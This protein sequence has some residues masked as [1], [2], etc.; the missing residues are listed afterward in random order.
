MS[1][2]SRCRV[3]ATRAVLSACALLSF[4][5]IVGC[6]SS[7]PSSEST[8]PTTPSFTASVSSVGN[9][10]PG[11]IGAV[12]QIVVSN[13]AGAA[14]SSGTVTVTETSATN[15]TVTGTPTG[16]GWTCTVTGQTFSC[17]SSAAEGGG[18]SFPPINVTGNVTGPAGGTVS[19]SISISGG[20]ITGTVNSTPTGISIVAPPTISKAFGASGIGVGGSTSLTFTVANPAANTVV[21]TGLA[22]SDSFPAGLAVAATPGVTDTCSGTVTAAAGSGTISLANGTSAAPGGTCTISVNVTATAAGSFSN[23]VNGAGTVKSSNGGTGVASNTAILNAAGPPT[24]SKAFGAA[25][26]PLTNGNTTLTFTVANPAAN[27]AALTGVAFSDS[28]PAGL[29]MAATPG[30]TDTCGG[31]VTAAAG[32]GTVSLANG[33]SA[34]PG[35]TCTISVNVTGTSAGAKPNTTGAISSTQSGAGAVSNTATLTVVAPPTISKAFGASSVSLNG[36]TSLSF[37]VT[38][39]NA[40]NALSGV[41]F[42]DSLPTGIAVSTPNG[43]TGSCGTGTISAVAGTSSVNL[44]SGTLASGG[45]CNFSVNVTGTTAGALS[46]TTGNVTSAEGGTGSAS[47]TASLAVVAPPTISKAFGASGVAVNATTTLTFTITNPAANTVGLTGVAFSDTLPTGLLIATPNGLANTCNGTPTATAGAGTVSLTGGTVGVSTNCTLTVNVTPTTAGT[48]PNTTGAVSS[49]NGGT[50]AVSNTAMLNGAAPPTISKAFS[51]P[52]IPLSSGNATL[53]FTITNPATNPVALTG[54]AFSDALPTGLVIATP[55][56]LANTCGGTPTATAASGSITLAGGTLPINN[57]CTL[58]VN[59]T[60]TTAGAKL[61][62]TGAVSSTQSGTGAVSNTATLT[63]LAPPTVSKAFGASSVSL[64]GSTSLSFTVT[65]PNATNTLSGVGFSDSLPT[66]LAV[67]TPNGLTGSCGTGTLSAVAGSSSVS[68]SSG[69]LA[70]AGSCNFSVNVTGTTAGSVSNTTGNVTS[71]EGGAGTTS[72]TA[73]LTV[74]APPTISLAFGASGV[75]VNGTTTLTFTITNPS[76]NTAA[77]TGVAF[78]DA[79][80]A[81]LL[82]ATPSGLANTCAGT[83]TAAAGSGSISLT[84][85]TVGVNTTCTLTVNVTPNQAGSFPDTTGAVSSTNGGTGTASNTATLNAA[86]P[87]TISIILGTSEIPLNGS[88]TLT[89]LIANPS[90]NTVTLTGVQ[91]TDNLPA[92]LVLGS[93]PLVSNACGGTT[94]GVTGGPSSVGLSGVTLA[95]NATCAFVV[96]VT[97]TAAGTLNIQTLPIS[98]TQSGAGLASN[99]LVLVVVAPPTISKAFGA[100]GIAVGGATTLTFTI[101]NPAA[102]TVGLTGVA[103]GDTLPTGLV[104]AATPNLT[105][106]CAGTPTASAGSISLVNG[107]IAATG[108]NATCTL[109]VNVTPTVAGVF[110]N[111]TG[112][113]NSTNGGTG[114]VSNTAT[115]SAALPPTI[116]KA[117]GAP[118]IPLNT[119]TSLTFTI[120]N[121]AGNV[122][123]LTGLAFTDNLPTGLVVASTPNISNTC[124]GTPTATAGSGAV[125]L[126]G[127]TIATPGNTCTLSVNVTGNAAGVLSNTTAAVSSTQSGSGAASNTANLT[128][129]APP[130]ISKAFGGPVPV[131]GPTTLTFTITNPAANTVAQ[132]GV[133]FSDTFPTGLVVATPNGLTNTCSGTP[134]ATAGSGSVSLTGGTVAVNTTCTLTVNVTANQPGSLPNATGAIT[135]SNGGTGTA[136]NTANLTVE[137]PP[138]ISVAFGASGVTVGGTTTLTVTITNPA[139]N[140]VAQTG[141][142]FSDTLPTGL[143]IATPNGLANTCAGT[144]TATAGSGSISLAGGTVG[145]NTTCRLTVNVTANQAGSFPDTTGTVSSTNGGTG[146]VSNTATLIAAAAPTISKAFTASS[147][148]LNASTTLTF[149]ITNPAAN[150]EALTGLAFSDTFPTGLTVASTPNLTNTCAGTPVAAAGTVLLTGGTLAINSSC[151]FSVSVTGTAAGTL[152]NTTG[153]VSSTQSGAGAP[154][155]VAN[156]TVVAPPTISKAFAGSVAVGGTTTL[157]FTI[158]NPAANTVAQAGVAF[159]DT[160]PTGLVVASTPNLTNTCAGTPTG[161]AGS[162]SVA[163]TGGTVAVNTNCTLTVSVTANQAGSLSNTTGAVSST[164]GGTGTASNTATLNSV[165]PPTISKAFGA[166]SIGVNG[167]TTLTFTITN[168]VSNAAALTGVAFSDTFPTGLVMAATPGLTN[169]CAG[170]PTATAGSGSV[171]LTGG[172]VAVNANCAVSVNVTATAPGSFPNTTGAV[173]STN[174]GTGTASNTATLTAF[175]LPTIS[176]AFGAPTVPLN[177]TTTLTFTIANPAGNTTA[178]TGVAFSDAFPAGLAVAATPNLTNTCGGTPAASGGSVSLTGGTSAAPGSTCTLSV[179]VTGTTVGAKPN[180]TGTISS[181]QTG[182]GAVSNTATL[183]VLAP[184]TISKAFGASTIPLNGNTTLTFTITNPNALNSL[185]GVAFTDTLTNG[186]QVAATPALTNTCNGTV[187]GATSASTSLNLSGGTLL[188]GGSCTISLSV[189]G[190]TAINVNNTTSTLTSTEGGTG[191]TSNTAT[192]AVVGPPGLGKVFSPSTIG[193]GGTSILTFNIIQGTNDTG[194]TGLAFSDTFPTGMVM[195]PTVGLANS[196][197]GVVSGATA[198]SA[199][200]SLSGGAVNGA[201]V[202]VIQVN[203]TAA[204]PGSY[205]NTTGPISDTSGGTGGTASGTLTVLTNPTISKGFGAS[206]I[207]LNGTTSLSF[208]ISNP[209]TVTLT[210]LT[211]NDP[212]PAGLVVSTLFVLNSN[213]CNVAPTASAGAISVGISNATLAAGASCTFSINVTGTTTGA[214]PN[215]TGAISSTQTGTGPTSNTATLTVV[216]PPT[217]TKAFGASIIPLTGSTS[218]SFTINNPN[219]SPL[220]G[221]GFTDTFQTNLAILTPNGLSGSCGAGIISASAGST[222]L[223]LTGGTLSAGGSCTFSVNVRVGGLSG[224]TLTNTT[225][226]ITSNEGGTGLTSNTVSLTA[227]AAPAINLPSPDTAGVGSSI[228]ITGSNF[229]PSQSQVSGTVTINGAIATV[230]NW[231]STSITATVPSGA[232]ASGNVIVTVLGVASNPEAFTVQTCTTNCTISGQVTGPWNQGVS[233]ALSG[234][235]SATTTTDTN[236]NYTFTGLTT[237]TYTIT[238]NSGTTPALQGYNFSPTSYSAVNVNGNIT[239][240][241][242]TETSLVGS[243]SISGTI[244]YSGA[245]TGTTHNTLINAY[246]CT[247]CG[248]T[249]GTTLTSV[250]IAGG[251]L[252]TI[253][254]LGTGSYIVNA[255]IDA[256]DTGVYNA[257]NPEG[258]YTG[259]NGVVS[260]TN[261]NATSVNFAIADRS[262]PAVGALTPP[263]LQGVSTYAGASSGTA[264]IFYNPSQS[265]FGEEVGT[266]YKLYYGTTNPPTSSVTFA[267]GNSQD[268]YL[269]HGLTNGAQYYFQMSALDSSGTVEGA[270]SSITQITEPVTIQTPT[271]GGTISGQITFAGITPTG[272]LTVGLYSNNGVYIESVPAAGLT[273]PFT[274]SINAPAGN[275]QLFVV[276]DQNNDG[277]I[278]AGDVTN[279]VGKNGPPSVIVPSSG[280]TVALAVAAAPTYVTTNHQLF[281]GVSTY[282]VQVGINLGAELPISMTLF[283][284]PNVAVPFDMTASINNNSY[285]P[286]FSSTAIPVVGDLYQFLVTFENGS[287]Q[288]VTSTVTGVLTSSPTDQF[289]TN[290]QVVTSSPYSATVPEFTWTDPTSPAFYTLQVNV[291]GTNGVSENW[292]FPHDG[293][294]PSGTTSAVFNSDGRAN[295]SALSAGDTY[296]WSVTVQDANNNSATQVVSYTVPQAGVSPPTVSVVFNPTGIAVGGQTTMNFILANPNA[297]SSLSQVGFTD[298]L[299]SGLQVVSAGSNTCGGTPTGVTAGSTSVGL[300]GVTLPGNGGFNTQGQC[301]F[302]IVVTTTTPG[303]M[304]NSASNV[305]SLE[306]GTGSSTAG[307]VTVISIPPPTVTSLSTNSGPVGSTLII[308]G[309]NFGASQQLVTGTFSSVSLNGVGVPAFDILTWSNTSIQIIVPAGA[310]TGFVVVT[311]LGVSSATSSASAF[312]ITA[313]AITQVVFQSTPANTAPGAPIPQFTVALEDAQNNINTASSGPITMRIYPSSNPGS[314]TLSGTTSVTPVNGIATFSGL[315]INNVGTGYQLQASYAPCGCSGVSN[316]F[317]ITAS[318]LSILT[319]SSQLPT[320]YVGTTYPPTF[321]SATGGSGTGYTWSVASGALPTG[322]TLS[323]AGAISF[324]SPTAPGSFTF[325]AQVKDSL[326]NTTTASLTINVTSTLTVTTTSLPTGTINSQYAKN[327]SAFLMAAGGTTPYVSWTITSGSLPSGLTLNGGNGAIYGTPTAGGTFPVTFQ[328]KDSVGS[329]ASAS[330]SISVSSS[331]QITSSGLQTAEIL[332][333]YQNTLSATGGTQPYSNWTVVSGSLPAGLSL[334]SSTGSISGT[335]SNAADVTTYNFTVQVQDSASNTA[336]ADLSMVVISNLHIIGIAL[337]GANGPNNFNLPTGALGVAYPATTM[338]AAGGFPPYSNWSATGLPTG[339]SINPST[340]AISGTPTATGTFSSVVLQVKDSTGFTATS[341]TFSMKVNGS[342]GLVITTTSLL[343]A[344]A[345]TFYSAQLNATGGSNTGYTW[346][347]GNGLSGF[348]LSLSSAGVISGTPTGSTRILTTVTVTDSLSNTATTTLLLTIDGITPCGTGSESLLNGTYAVYFRGFMGAG[349]GSPTTAVASFTTDGHGNITGTGDEDFNASFTGGDVHLQIVPSGGGS[350]S[351]YSVGS[352]NRGCVT[353]QFNSG[354]TTTARF[355]LGGLTTINSTTVATSGRVIEFDDNSGNGSGTRGAGMIFRQTPAAFVGSALQPNYT[356]GMEGWDPSGGKVANVGTFT[357]NTTTGLVSAGYFDYNNAGTT[358]SVLGTASGFI[359]LAGISPTTGRTSMTFTAGSAT[360]DWEIYVINANQFLVVSIDPIGTNTPLTVGRI[361]ATGAP[362][363][364]STGSVNGSYIIHGTGFDQ[365]G[366][367][368]GVGVADTI[369]GL[370]NASNG[371]FGNGSTIYQYENGQPLQVQSISG[372]TYSVDPASGRMTLQNTGGGG[373]A[374]VFYLVTPTDDGIAAVFGGPDGS[375]AQFGYIDIQTNPGTYSNNSISGNYTIGTEDP[376]DNNVTYLSGTGPF[377]AG[378]GTV[379][380]DTSSLSGLATSP[381]TFTFEIGADGTGDIG[382]ADG[383]AITNGSKIWYLNGASGAPAFLRVFEQESP[384]LTIAVPGL[385]SQAVGSNYPATTF[386]AVGGSGTGYVWSIASGSLPLGLS[387]NTSTGALVNSPHPTTPNTYSFSLQ[388]IDSLGHT[389]TTG[390][391]SITIYPALA[392]TPPSSFPAGSVGASYPAQSFNASGG[393]GTGYTFTIASGSLPSPLIL[394]LNGSIASAIPMAAGTYSFTVKVTDSVGDTVTSSSLSI[395]VSAGPLSVIAPA[396]LPA[397]T[398]G[399]PYPEEGFG[400]LGGSGTGYVFT[401]ASGSLPPGLTLSS[402]GTIT[403]SPNPTTTT[404]SPFTFTVK[405]TDSLGATATSSPA[406]SITINANTG[407]VITPPSPLPN[408]AVGNSYIVGAFTASGGSGTGYTWAVATGALPAGLALGAGTGSITGSPTAAGTSPFTVMVTDSLGHTASTG[409]LSITVTGTGLAIS[410]SALPSGLPLSHY[411]A[412]VSASGGTPPYGQYTVAGGTLPA[413]YSL[414]ANTGEITGVTSSSAPASSFTVQVKD[415]QGATATKSLSITVNATLTINATSVSPGFVGTPY[416]DVLTATGGT[417]TGYTWSLVGGSLPTPLAVSNLTVGSNV[418]GQISGTITSS[419]GS[420]TF[421]IQVKDSGNNIATSTLFMEVLP[422][423]KFTTN[424]LPTGV[425]GQTYPGVSLGA[426]PYLAGGFPPYKNFAITSGSLPAGLNLDPN[427]GTIS[428]NV[429]SSASVTT[430]SFT[431]QAQD[432]FGETASSSTLFLAINAS[433]AITT[434]SVPTGIV[435]TPYSVTLAA[436]GGILPYTWSGTAPT[437]YTLGSNGVLSG[438]PTIASSANFVATVTDSSTPT[439]IV[440]RVRLT[441]VTDSAMSCGTGNEGILNGSYAFYAQG[442]QGGGLGSYVVSAGSFTANGA[443]GISGGDFDNNTA[444]S[445]GGNVHATILSSGSSY[446]VGPDN[447]G[448]MTLALSS[449][450]PVVFHFALGGVGGNSAGVAAKGRFESWSATIHTSGIILQ[451]T[452][453]AFSNSALAARFAFGMDG[454]DASGNHAAMGGS[455]GLGGGTISSGYFDFTDGSNGSSASLY[456]VAGTASGSIG[457]VS[458]TGRATATYNVGSNILDW[459]I[460]VVNENQFFV[461]S[462][463]TLGSNTPL[464]VGRAISTASSFT[465]GTFSG[466]YIFHITGYVSSQDEANIVLGRLSVDGSGNISTGSLYEYVN[467]LDAFI[468][469]PLTGT[470]SIGPTSGRAVLNSG[471]SNQPILYLVNPTPDGI[472]AFV[473]DTDST[474]GF[475]ISEI[476][477]AGTYSN[478]SISGSYIYGPDELG[479]NTDVTAGQQASVGSANFTAGVGTLVHDNSNPNGGILTTNA[480]T[481]ICFAI[482]PDGTGTFAFGTCGAPSGIAITNGTKIFYFQYG[483]NTPAQIHVYEQ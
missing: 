44:S 388:V 57:N 247:G 84:G 2:P 306:G 468:Y 311:V 297:S 334:N 462:A 301:T 338:S 202:C 474:A 234:G 108:A 314:G 19:V 347:G 50:G 355:A 265:S 24:I 188:A 455:F 480:P 55:N 148:P 60:G 332:S 337:P 93:T 189:K 343:P 89:F 289:A 313:G 460:Y 10:S 237:G 264:L 327:N 167:T 425:P 236:G 409:L 186:L 389:A 31:T 183:T 113:V 169:T 248:P 121:P 249:A 20:G 309:T 157:T 71:T 326:S 221:V 3:G 271:G 427:L 83:P 340:G 201:G 115:L 467:E 118:S 344:N 27:L 135:S 446:S 454:F 61:N 403:N 463:D 386:S 270:K 430:Y 160:F 122:A 139:A 395:V 305:T 475:G 240:E 394:E 400:A 402:N 339:L 483:E 385:P 370:I 473:I 85:A 5:F 42:T 346:S 261:A 259:N 321:L 401:I 38:N 420:Y 15:F 110:P 218:L 407:L 382:F 364:F 426:S 482:N 367:T 315:S 98:S 379:Q 184:A 163:L 125:S 87:P 276:L 119:N 210:G 356:I 56:G 353:L 103:F 266:S 263:T 212:L 442:F 141:V 203:V 102:N 161:T 18:Q 165:A 319:T 88:T 177:G 439:A 399:V 28:F 342:G 251:T 205:V 219:S 410:T 90:V 36:S 390:T 172:A 187:G 456:S 70:A 371:T 209:T 223:S 320:G 464:T 39:P 273:S 76:A 193:A 46:N 377:T 131:G 150:T 232:T 328:V 239:G 459:V 225:S 434:T 348:G 376:G 445:N 227:L 101:T 269:L 349:V 470:Y 92:G 260:I 206:T 171:S 65:N 279:F 366:S 262:A 397:G 23:T 258:G 179:N 63:V 432:T 285:Q 197:G 457:S 128:V 158:T 175:A 211:F 233:I 7:G 14:A 354:Q 252:Y 82:V 130:T 124:A 58:S 123:A 441:V 99:N 116:S 424:P 62:T 26:I 378:T 428:G 145:V 230:T 477:P 243:F 431:V 33:T 146:T 384:A 220:T 308:N 360:F 152:S 35:G 466:S 372:I 255:E 162:G 34:A 51:V 143:V 242:F 286:I 129:V 86:A 53:T 180:T 45:T 358:A 149:T 21:Q 478:N 52:T 231:T 435:G 411:F 453:S 274:Y 341:P 126:T 222:S 451:Q 229:G 196:C 413:G 300:S 173:T 316:T 363:S 138:T 48:F 283:S 153:T 195:A 418:D 291:N 292:S 245:F 235:A 254:G 318:A 404:G 43:L 114:L 41:A 13:A 374:P 408:G 471:G 107:A 11:Q 275:Y 12:Y 361:F 178:L 64:N 246:P 191:A 137:A 359:S 190:T 207:P 282:S 185:S 215:T 267:A 438:T 75:A 66:G 345:G 166:P 268:V 142:A 94:A 302:S 465:T 77:L 323:G 73:N 443:G 140:T 174:G 216:A 449:G 144:P 437:G 450:G 182:T 256:Q 398:I 151:T 336:R 365:T 59:V 120:T 32:S 272:P 72:N 105:N 1:S 213:T 277:V 396:S 461:M 4:A 293:S 444:S 95:A 168:P 156:L 79:L 127:G 30:V 312:T 393:S 481:Q 350:V 448:C 133:A 288:V 214:K 422:Q 333:T 299:N 405:V 204:T 324:T 49:T 54:V 22:F 317:K 37:T 208:T 198:G 68:L 436:T 224:G 106:T 244:T 134:T 352:D 100:S 423:F 458:G 16:S 335:I 415:S 325:T 421:T 304:S 109:S 375:D 132:A 91:F 296:D 47:N 25:T 357:L 253:R 362:G 154:S 280:P 217:I 369:L 164:N 147:V 67:S 429:S 278:D 469:Q 281:G 69:T 81:N 380:R 80:P 351:S 294:L 476:Q 199:S 412:L 329:T 330:L 250:P 416:V 74:E 417:G 97:G 96:S 310:P 200:I 290:L 9:V 176:K 440:A 303:V 373:G 479:D 307:T 383:V 78:T 29:A 111:T 322:L 368:A 241:N 194:A 295:P 419:A 6:T 447:R 406:S 257:S 472:A 298:I 136:S 112:A 228:I 238:V 392:I 159:T 40:T 155:N 381:A 433:L 170:T 331:L 8:A 104:V 181:T 117:F 17:T 391:L 387:L 287:T 452:Q 226:A 284:A 192:L 414:N